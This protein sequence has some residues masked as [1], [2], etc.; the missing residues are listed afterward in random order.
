M[1]RGDVPPGIRRTSVLGKAQNLGAGRIYF[2]RADKR[3][4][5]PQG[6]A[7][8]GGED[9]SAAVKVGVEALKLLIAEDRAG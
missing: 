7:L 3:E 9:T 8:W 4:G 2:A 5:S 6:E 1:S